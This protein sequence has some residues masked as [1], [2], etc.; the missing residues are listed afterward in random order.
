MLRKIKEE[1]KV[2]NSIIDDMLKNQ[3]PPKKK[4]GSKVAVVFLIIL[5]ILAVAAAV[6]A[7]LYLKKQNEVTPKQYFMQY[8]GKINT[9]EILNFEKMDT[10]QTRLQNEAEEATT[11]IS[12]TVSSGLFE[13]ELDLS[14]LKL[15]V[16]SKNDPVK[17]KNSSDIILTYKGMRLLHLMR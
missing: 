7:V 3:V 17:E 14:E 5:L 16:N 15:E 12:A 1:M 8:L 6:V 2:A 11:E 4:S 13:S 10:F 9:S